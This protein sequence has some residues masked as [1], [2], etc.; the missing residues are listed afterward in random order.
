[1]ADSPDTSVRNQIRDNLRAYERP[2][3]GKRTAFVAQRRR[4]SADSIKRLENI[5]TIQED[6][7]K[8]MRHQS[9]GSPSQRHRL[10]ASMKDL[11]TTYRH[12]LQRIRESAKTLELSWAMLE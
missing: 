4:L 12:T 6:R 10:R 9:G 5:I 8:Q 7:V 3:F 11:L 2:F 1:M